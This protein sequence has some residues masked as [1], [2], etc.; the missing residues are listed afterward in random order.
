MSGLSKKAPAFPI[1]V[2]K[3]VRVKSRKN[4]KVKAIDTAMKPG[5]VAVGALRRS[6]ADPGNTERSSE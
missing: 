4:K 6:G 5:V 1:L 3:A 2:R